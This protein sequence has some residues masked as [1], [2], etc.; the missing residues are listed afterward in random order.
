MKLNF[1]QENGKNSILIK[2]NYQLFSKERPFETNFERFSYEMIEIDNKSFEGYKDIVV[3]IGIVLNYYA[4]CVLVTTMYFIWCFSKINQIY[5]S[6]QSRINS[7]L[8]WAGGFGKFCFL[9]RCYRESMKFQSLVYRNSDMTG[10]CRPFR[11]CA[12]MK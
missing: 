6:T 1:S 8:L 7:S 11:P 12:L 10:N 9:V 2:G 4:Q 5:A 3:S